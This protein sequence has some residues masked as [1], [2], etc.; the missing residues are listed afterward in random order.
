MGKLTKR[1]N[2]LVKMRGEL[3]N[4]L[5]KL[6]EMMKIANVRE[7]VESEIQ[8][9]IVMRDLTVVKIK[10]R[11]LQ[12]YYRKKRSFVEDVIEADDDNFNPEL[13]ELNT[14]RPVMRIYPKIPLPH[15]QPLWEK[16]VWVA[17]RERQRYTSWHG[18]FAGVEEEE[19][20]KD[21]RVALN[22]VVGLSIITATSPG[23]EGLPDAVEELDHLKAL[24]SFDKIAA[25]IDHTPSREVTTDKSIDDEVSSESEEEVFTKIKARI[26]VKMINRIK[27]IVEQNSRNNTKCDVR[28][29]SRISE[30]ESVEIPGTE[31]TSPKNI[32]TA[33]LKETSDKITTIRAKLLVPPPPSSLH[34]HA[35]ATAAAEKP[36]TLRERLRKRLITKTKGVGLREI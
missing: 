7:E 21:D 3:V 32:Q 2:E 11:N 19:E 30:E 24:F 16:V 5:E 4:K 22:N 1:L 35:T 26:D 12:K 9:K 17:R 18:Q 27:T 8:T 31:S 15:S 28:G 25:S 14:T 29:R 36:V 6:N 23:E 20:E 13:E 34:T 10:L 33:E